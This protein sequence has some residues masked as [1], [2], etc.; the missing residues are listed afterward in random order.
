MTLMN[1]TNLKE[2]KMNN[3]FANTYFFK[4]ILPDL[5]TFKEFLAEYTTVDNTDTFNNYCYKFIFN[6]FCNSNIKYDTPDAFCRHFGITYENVFDQF[7]VRQDIINKSYNLSDDEYI[8]ARQVII[9]NSLNDNLPAPNPLDEPLEYISNQN[10]S[11]ETMSKID[12]YIHAI[13]K[14]TD[15]LLDEFLDEFRKHFI[16]L[17]SIDFALY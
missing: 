4:D 9:N 1:L 17:Y 13:Y 8:L 5:D 14:L 6:R 11:R 2:L 3:L 10:A 12:G 15:N 16:S 7:K